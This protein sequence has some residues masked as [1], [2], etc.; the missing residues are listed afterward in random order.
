MS[1]HVSATNFQQDSPTVYIVEEILKKVLKCIKWFI[2]LLIAAILGI[3]SVATTAPVAG[4]A[5]HQSVQT[6]QFVQEWHKDS[7]VL[8]S[9][10]RK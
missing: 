1:F 2:G 10:Q 8:W 5:L 7:D 9:I 6:V 3:T 4:V